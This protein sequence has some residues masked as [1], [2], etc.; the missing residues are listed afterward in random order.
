MALAIL[1]FVNANAMEKLVGYKDEVLLFDEFRRRLL[2]SLCD[3]F[4]HKYK[5]IPL[6][7]PLLWACVCDLKENIAFQGILPNNRQKEKRREGA[8]QGQGWSRK[9]N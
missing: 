7:V 2:N 5:M 9:E 3:L 8:S 1:I 6:L 4:K